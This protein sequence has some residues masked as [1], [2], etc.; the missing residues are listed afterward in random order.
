MS[1]VV[2]IE[3]SAD[4]FVV[5]GR[6]IEGI[7]DDCIGIKCVRLEVNQIYKFFNKIPASGV[8]SGQVMGGM[9]MPHRMSSE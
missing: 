2:S 6:E 7:S 5:G 8:P 1:G 3:V 4:T 9:Q